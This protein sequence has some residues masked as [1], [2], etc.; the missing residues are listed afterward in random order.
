MRWLSSAI[1]VRLLT[2]ASLTDRSKAVKRIRSAVCKDLPARPC[3]PF[4]VNRL[5]MAAGRGSAYNALIE[6]GCDY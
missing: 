3:G 4:R 2:D 1:V 6:A 5:P